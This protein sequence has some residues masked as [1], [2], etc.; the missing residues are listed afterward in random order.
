MSGW[1]EAIEWGTAANERR[2]NSS[3]IRIVLTVALALSAPVRV[4][5]SANHA[6]IR[7]AGKVSVAFVGHRG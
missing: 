7:A 5:H 3:E 4:T 1:F 6:D 2:V